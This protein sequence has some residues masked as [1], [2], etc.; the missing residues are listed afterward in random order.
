MVSSPVRVRDKDDAK[1]SPND[2]VMLQ[3]PSNVPKKEDDLMNAI[4]ALSGADSTPAQPVNSKRNLYVADRADPRTCTPS[5][6][7]DESE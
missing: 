1:E 3:R 5:R 4:R 2:S 6:Y 7:W